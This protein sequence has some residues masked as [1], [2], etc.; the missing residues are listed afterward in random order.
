MTTGR[1]KYIRFLL[2]LGISLSVPLFL[3][4]P[5]YVDLSET[6]F[7]SSDTSLE[8]PDDEDL[9]TFQDE[10]Q[11]FAPDVSWNPLLSLTYCALEFSLFSP[12]FTSH[13]QLVPVPRC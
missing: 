4:Y 12:V 5:V 13:T 8:D 11:G 2:I 9:S 1:L 6:E 7:F 3:A 10:S